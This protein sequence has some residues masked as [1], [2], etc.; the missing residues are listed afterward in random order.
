MLL[1][2]IQASALKSCFE[3]LKE[4]LHDVNMYFDETGIS[5]TALDN[6]KVALINLKLDAEN[7]EVYECKEVIQAGIN[8]SNFY[9]IMKVITSNDVLT[10]EMTN[11]EKI[12]VIIE[13]DTKNS[14]TR[15]EL[16]LLWINEDMLQLPEIKPDCITTLASIDFQRLC[17]D[18]GNIGQDVSI[19]RNNNMFVVKCNGEFASQETSID[20]EQ[21]N[22]D[23]EIGGNYSLK[24]INMFTKA[25]SMCSNMQIKQ[26]LPTDKMPIAFSYDVANLG[27]IEFYLVARL[28]DTE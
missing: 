25:T 27:K 22:F 19:S 9:K 8:V 2:T 14:T 5:I 17:R 4:A 1:K 10:L 18:M 7:F 16:C 6:A 3:V 24:Y 11:T 28:D 13:N 12:R 15:F 21:N 20:T 23:G 26:T